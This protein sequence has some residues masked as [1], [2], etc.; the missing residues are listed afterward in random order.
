ML[1]LTEVF[2]CEGFIEK[3]FVVKTLVDKEGITAKS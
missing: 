1:S 2:K 3:P